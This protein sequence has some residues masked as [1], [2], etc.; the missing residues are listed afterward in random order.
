MVSR[1]R[2]QRNAGAKFHSF[3]PAQAD[4]RDGTSYCKRALFAAELF[5]DIAFAQALLDQ[6]QNAG[7]NEPDA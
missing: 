7:R 3:R 5:G 6:H 1:A 2:R 4:A